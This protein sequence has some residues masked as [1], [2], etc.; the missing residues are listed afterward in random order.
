MQTSELLDTLIMTLVKESG[1][2]IHLISGLVPALRVHG[3]LI[4]LVRMSPL[5]P[6]EVLLIVKSLINDNQYERLIKERQI[7]F[8]YSHRGEYRL[9][10]NAFFQ[11][12]SL[13]ISFRLIPKIKS[14]ADLGLPSILLDFAHK[15]Q[16]FAR[17]HR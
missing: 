17:H 8:A 15:K 4:S 11:R 6:E 1:S 16:G 13:A 5:T 10:A 9:R 12:N 14:I 2:D 7:D 3:E